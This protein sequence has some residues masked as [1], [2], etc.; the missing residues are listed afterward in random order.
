M[1]TKVRL[2]DFAGCDEIAQWY[3]KSKGQIVKVCTTHE[4]L[5][6]RQHWG[7]RID[8]SEL[9]EDDIRRLE[10]KVYWNEYEKKHPFEVMLTPSEDEREVKVHDLQTSEWRSFMIK[11]S[12]T[13]RFD[14]AY[15]H[16][17]KEGF[18]PKPSIDDYVKKLRNGVG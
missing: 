15:R 8:Y 17:E 10:T 5:L 4:A 9:D 2:C 7:R 14:E 12:D 16:L 3:R 18:D 13:E 1:R 6:A 11:G